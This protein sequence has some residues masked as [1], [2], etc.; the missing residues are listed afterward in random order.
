MLFIISYRLCLSIKLYKINTKKTSWTTCGFKRRFIFK[1][2]KYS[3][4]ENTMKQCFSTT[5][6]IVTVTDAY[7]EI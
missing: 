2:N 5:L 4:E 6:L 3:L 1:L 7:K